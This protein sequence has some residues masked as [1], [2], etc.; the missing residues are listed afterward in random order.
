MNRCTKIKSSTLCRSAH[1]QQRCNTHWQTLQFSKIR[2]P[3]RSHCVEFFQHILIA[4][5]NQGHRACQT[6]RWGMHSHC[7]DFVLLHRCTGEKRTVTEITK[8]RQTWNWIWQI[9]FEHGHDSCDST[10]CDSR[11]GFCSFSS[12]TMPTKLQGITLY[13][14]AQA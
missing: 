7:L 6:N 4:P 13:G 5:R 11:N 12:T 2:L 14:S 10:S 9:H 8:S 3:S 1:Y